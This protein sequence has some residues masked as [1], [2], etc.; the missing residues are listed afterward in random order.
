MS[1]SS[2]A[3]VLLVVLFAGGAWAQQ[4]AAGE[5]AI[6]AYVSEDAISAL[7]IRETDVSQVG[8]TEISGGVFFNED[9]DLVATGT[10]LAAIG[11]PQAFT[12]FRLRVGP[13]AYASF[14]H[15]E[16]EDVFGLAVGGEARYLLGPERGG[17]IV[18][19]LFYAPDILVFGSAD[20]VKD[21]TIRFEAGLRGDTMVFVGYRWLEMDL[22]V[23]RRIE[24]GAHIGFRRQF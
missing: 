18:L 11:S 7:Y 21:A 22:D 4:P 13:R 12:R 1:N 17:S 23:D 19:S 14:L 8:R 20:G 6:E 5:H 9:R 15:T 16:D 10:A 2:K 3:T 24:D